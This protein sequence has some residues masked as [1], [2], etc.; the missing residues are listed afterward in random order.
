MGSQG[1]RTPHDPRQNCCSAAPNEALDY[2]ASR[3]IPEL[4]LPEVHGVLRFHSRCPFG[5]PRAAPVRALGLGARMIDIF[6]REVE[7]VFVSLRVAAIL[8]APVGQYPQQLY[9]LADLR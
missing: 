6:D 7:L 9:L 3:A 5:P 2:F 8:T 4:R 1:M